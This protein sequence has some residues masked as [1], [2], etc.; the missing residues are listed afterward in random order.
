MFSILNPFVLFVLVWLLMLIT[1]FLQISCFMV[2]K[3]TL[4]FLVFFISVL[5][6]LFGYLFCRII[7]E[8]SDFN[9]CR[10]LIKSQSGKVRV[11][12]LI[13]S[14]IK[15]RLVYIILF[16]IIFLIVFLNFIMFGNP[17]IL[18]FFGK[19]VAFNYSTYGRFKGILFPTLSVLFLISIFDRN[20]LLS[21]CIKLF[22][23]LIFVIYVTRGFIIST[24]I[25][26]IFLRILLDRKIKIRTT[27]KYAFLLLIAILFIMSMI[28]NYRTGNEIFKEVME[29]KKE[30]YDWPAALL[31]VIGYISFPLVN[32]EAF[33][34]KSD[35]FFYGKI[36]L[37]NLL[38]AFINILPTNFYSFYRNLLP[39]QFNT[40]STYL[41]N[42]YLDFGFWGI[43]FINICLGMTAY[44]FYRKAYENVVL[45]SVFYSALL[46]IF[47][48][49]YFFY[50]P[51]FFES[52]L[53][54]LIYRIVIKKR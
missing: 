8:I 22:V 36:T 48:S 28:G 4:L 16:I 50:F 5:C 25:Q 10:N 46:L 11:N 53:A 30:F 18:G 21:T 17:P 14:S 39:N 35:H 32:L 27:F 7:F 41:G 29:I 37:Q 34:C 51:F 9:I 42:V 45:T 38:P 15:L 2:P 20:K 12:R 47:F 43:I 49:N 3:Y 52:V 23:M 6:F 40:V 13:V 19:R 31:W 24:L 44:I 54:V 33:I 1:Y 26:Y